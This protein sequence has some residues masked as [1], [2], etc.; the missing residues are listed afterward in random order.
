MITTLGFAEPAENFESSA[1]ESSSSSNT[2]MNMNPN[3][4]MNTNSGRMLFKNEDFARRKRTPQEPSSLQALLA[5]H[6]IDTNV[7]KTRAQLRQPGP[8]VQ[9]LTPQR[10]SRY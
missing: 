9:I 3:T 10:D 4:N 8:A 2:N 1:A 7:L 5:N 6:R